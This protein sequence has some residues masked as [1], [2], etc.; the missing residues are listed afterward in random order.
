MNCIFNVKFDSLN[1]GKMYS[2]VVNNGVNNF[3]GGVVGWGKR[4]WDGLVFVGVREIFG[5]GKIE[6]GESVKFMFVSEDG[7]EG[8]LGE[9]KVMVVYIVGK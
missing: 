5:V 2:L 8:F 3:Y 4:V 6:G 1:G 9:V 7:D